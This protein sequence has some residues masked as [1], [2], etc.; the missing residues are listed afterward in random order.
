MT[1][2]SSAAYNQSQRDLIIMAVTSQ[3][4]PAQGVGNVQVGHW[5]AAGLLLGTQNFL[6]LIFKFSFANDSLLAQFVQLGQ[7][8]V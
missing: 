5:R 1:V 4:R 3:L 8:R 6:L 7:F 2:V